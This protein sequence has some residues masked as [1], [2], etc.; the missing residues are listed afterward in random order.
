MYKRLFSKWMWIPAGVVWLCGGAYAW[1]T[2]HKD[3]NIT[4]IIDP[5]FTGLRFL[6]IQAPESSEKD[7]VKW[8]LTDDIVK[9]ATEA[10]NY[11]AEHLHPNDV[12]VASFPRSGTTWISELVYLLVTKLNYEDALRYNIEERVPFMEYIW[13]GVRSI[14][15]STPPRVIKTHLPFPFL[16]REVSSL[17][18]LIYCGWL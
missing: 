3:R 17:L 18:L 6:Q 11:L 15:K 13:P 2:C 4:R 10:Q 1:N 16:P 12:F 7:S 14:A 8:Y 5:E 9:A